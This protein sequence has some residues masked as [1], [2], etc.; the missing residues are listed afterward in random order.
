MAVAGYARQR[1]TLT[2]AT[3]W[4][5]ESPTAQRRI[6]PD[7]VMDLMWF[8]ER[9]VVAGADTRTMIA[10]TRPGEPTWGIQLAPGVAHTLLGLPVR[11]LTDQRV[12]LSDIVTVPGASTGDIEHIAS[13][14]SA[15]PTALE[16]V[17]ATLW[18]AADP[19]VTTLRLASSL[20]RAARNRMTVRETA[21]HHNISERTLRRVSDD[22]F[23]YGP[24]MLTQIH[25]FNQALT[26]LR[27]G[28]PISEVAMSAGY[29]DHAHLTRECRRFAGQPPSE[30][31][32]GAPEQAS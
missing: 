7:G 26:L 4:R 5:A 25:R 21:V 13:D 11:E 15:I 31:A 19:D 29:S 18:T 23:G 6:T 27:T 14:N 10:D 8:R 9:L 30:L 1:G 16:Q 28:T 2:G 22:L 3:L 32:G 20:D 12:E 24:N 17:F